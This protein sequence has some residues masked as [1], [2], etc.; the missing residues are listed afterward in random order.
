MGPTGEAG[1]RAE[2]SPAVQWA[3]WFPSQWPREHQYPT[4]YNVALPS[5]AKQWAGMAPWFCQ[6]SS[7]SIASSRN[8]CMVYWPLST[9]LLNT[10]H[11]VLSALQG[12]TCKNYTD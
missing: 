6:S 12:P 3:W 11:L 1:Q 10:D 8:M 7:N 4:V 5:G 9:S 2:H